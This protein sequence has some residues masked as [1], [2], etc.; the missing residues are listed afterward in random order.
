M[1]AIQFLSSLMMGYY[2]CIRPTYML[3]FSVVYLVAIS[4]KN[5]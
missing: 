5:L 1:T 3:G 2:T 4:F